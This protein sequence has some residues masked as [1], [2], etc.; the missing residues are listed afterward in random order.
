[1]ANLKFHIIARSLAPEIA[2]DEILKT[3]RAPSFLQAR[4]AFWRFCDKKGKEYYSLDLV[5]DG[6]ENFAIAHFNNSEV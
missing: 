2:G 1:M 3:F 6:D 5:E 4:C